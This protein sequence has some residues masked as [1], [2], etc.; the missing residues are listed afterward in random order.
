VENV[1]TKE[2]VPVLGSDDEKGPEPMEAIADKLITDSIAI[3]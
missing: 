1:P 3:F 2:N